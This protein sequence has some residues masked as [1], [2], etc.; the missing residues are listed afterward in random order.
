M[1]RLF[2]A[3]EIPREI[4]IH[5]AMMRG[6]LPGARWIDPENYHMTLRFVGDVDLRA[7]H[8]IDEV[9]ERVRRPQISL[10]LLGLDA[11]GGAKPHSLFAGVDAGDALGEL[12]SEI[13]RRMRRL[14]LKPDGRR[15]VPHVTLA[16]LRG[17][18]D[19]EVA[20]YL[21]LRG[22]F[23]SVRFVAKRFALLSSRDSIGGG[24]YVLEAA[25]PLQDRDS[26]A[27]TSDPARPRAAP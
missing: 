17:A 26:R 16:R 6:G 25:Y 13:E 8:A 1:P 20:N 5:L 15:F 10:R 27:A 3:I 18:R 14:G 7:A 19:H 23:S 12:Q 9:L 2:T 24:P 21:S 11:F 22:N 4:G